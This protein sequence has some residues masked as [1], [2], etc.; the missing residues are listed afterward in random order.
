MK[1]RP[2]IRT[3]ASPRLNGL[4]S[5]SRHKRYYAQCL[6]NAVSRCRLTPRHWRDPPPSYGT[7]SAGSAARF[8]E[9]NCVLCPERV[10][11]VCH[12][13]CGTAPR[14]PQQCSTRARRSLH[15]S[16]H[17]LT[18]LGLKTKFSGV[19]G[20]PCSPSPSKGLRF[21][22][23]FYREGISVASSRVMRWKAIK[24]S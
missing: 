16:R 18:S 2:L 10:W 22:L 24:T 19:E 23:G 7:S 3:S 12:A 21:P 11:A 4:A 15:P 5:D 1:E 17:T 9:Y 14:P 20:H 13:H 6:P 8:I